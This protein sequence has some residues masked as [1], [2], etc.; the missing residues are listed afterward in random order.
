M[1]CDRF[2][3]TEVI[4]DMVTRETFDKSTGLRIHVQPLNPSE[5]AKAYGYEEHN[6]GYQGFVES[7]SDFAVGDLIRVT[8][9]AGSTGRTFVGETFWVR[10]LEDNSV[11]P[12]IDHRLLILNVSERST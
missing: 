12:G 5:R 10:G 7:T 2:R 6:A 4:E 9:V 8:R 3:P 11:W 1:R